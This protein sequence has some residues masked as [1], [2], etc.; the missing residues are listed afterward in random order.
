MTQDAPHINFS[1]F[2]SNCIKFQLDGY[3]K[4]LF[5]FAPGWG[6]GACEL[7]SKA[8]D[9]WGKVELILQET[10]SNY[11]GHSGSVVEVFS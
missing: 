9:V 5:F 1:P 10:I 3:L 8:L 11:R 7:K 4:C 2:N 6:W